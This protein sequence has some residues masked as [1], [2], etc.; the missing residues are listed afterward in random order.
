MV[1]LIYDLKKKNTHT[2]NEKKNGESLKRFTVWRLF[3]KYIIGLL[4]GVF[5]T[6]FCVCFFLAPTRGLDEERTHGRGS[7]GGVR[8][9]L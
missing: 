4:G 3:A 1:P 8:V 5:L 7:D 9:S 6:C 2:Q